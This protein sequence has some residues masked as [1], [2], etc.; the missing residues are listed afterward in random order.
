MQ[1]SR[2]NTVVI[3]EEILNALS[4]SAPASF[5]QKAKNEIE[6][7]V[8]ELLK[9][10]NIFGNENQINLREYFRLMDTLRILRNNEFVT[11]TESQKKEIQQHPIYK[12]LIEIID[13]KIK[14]LSPG[15]DISEIIRQIAENPYTLTEEEMIDKIKN[16]AIKYKIS[17]R[18]IFELFKAVTQDINHLS[19]LDINR[20]DDKE[21]L[22]NETGKG[23]TTEEIQTLLQQ[24]NCD[25]SKADEKYRESIRTKGNFE[26][27][28]GVIEWCK[29]NNLSF[30]IEKQ[31]YSYLI[32][33]SNIKILN[34]MKKLSADEKH[35]FDLAEMLRK[36]PASFGIEGK[37]KGRFDT[38]KQNIELL[39][40]LGYTMDKILKAASVL[41]YPH[42]IIK[43][44]VEVLKQYGY[45]NLPGINFAITSLK[46]PNMLISIAQIIEQN[47]QD[48][49]MRSSSSIIG[50]Y[51]YMGNYFAK[52]GKTREDYCVFDEKI[53]SEIQKAVE[54][55]AQTT[56][57]SDYMDEQ[58]DELEQFRNSE[59][60]Y[61][62]SKDNQSALISSM[63][64]KTIYPILLEKYPELEKD[65]LLLFATTYRSILTKDQFDMIRKI[66]LKEKTR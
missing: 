53:D 39:S 52:K 1:A 26:N 43:H 48:H 9:Y 54:E 29:E 32:L 15:S 30:D 57:P 24:Y 14:E 21:K 33:C 35:K 20:A 63:K 7:D 3:L 64:V 51:S 6:K 17:K 42:K 50:Q 10:Q 49:F 5:Y 34:E 25:I 4:S 45:D 23:L 55:P 16:I 41:I 31:E 62:F 46:P 47:E 27:I 44:N 59:R 18:K 36:L 58:I 28:I 56:I 22:Q 40:Q 12:T 8:F 66:V 2:N 11:L 61:L 37:M 19:S 13:K 38:F 65:K 60:T